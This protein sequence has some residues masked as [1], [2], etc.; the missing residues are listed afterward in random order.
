[1]D[2]FDWFKE[3]S[4]K[5]LDTVEFVNGCFNLDVITD[6]SNLLL[7]AGQNCQRLYT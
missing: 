7:P 1:M 6:D 4:A 2:P 5:I 3:F